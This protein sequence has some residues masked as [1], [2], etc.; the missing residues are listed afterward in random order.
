MNIDQSKVLYK[1]T[2]QCFMLVTSF[3]L[4]KPPAFLYKQSLAHHV[5]NNYSLSVWVH[6]CVF[7]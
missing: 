2:L 3:V 6:V 5:E 4:R 1:Y 7:I